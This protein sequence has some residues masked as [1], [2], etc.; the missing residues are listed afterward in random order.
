MKV[1][2]KLVHRVMVKRTRKGVELRL[3]GRGSSG[4]YYALG[5]VPPGQPGEKVPPVEAMEALLDPKEL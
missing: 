3:L 4:A 2:G 5:V 1:K